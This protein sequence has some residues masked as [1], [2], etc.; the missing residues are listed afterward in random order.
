[1]WLIFVAYML[2]DSLMCVYCF[3][4]FPECELCFS[5]LIASCSDSWCCWYLLILLVVSDYCCFVLFVI[6]DLIYVLLFWC[7]DLCVWCWWLCWWCWCI[8]MISEELLVFCWC[9][10]CVHFMFNS[11]IVSVLFDSVYRWLMYRD[12]FAE[13][14]CFLG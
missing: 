8:W 10:L 7:F 12:V 2:W 1:M 11:Q 4:C 13:F 14:Y 9:V 5:F 6:D 3:D